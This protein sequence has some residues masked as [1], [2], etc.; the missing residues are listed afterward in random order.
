MKYLPGSGPTSGAKL[1]VITDAPTYSDE[2]DGKLFSGYN[3]RALEVALKEAGTSKNSCWITS[4]SKFHIQG[5]AKIPLKIRAEKDGID[6]EQQLSELRQE[7]S[8]IKPNCILALGNTAMTYLTGKNGITKYRG[9][10]LHG[11]GT[12]V[13]PAYNPIQLNSY[14]GAEFIGYY[15]KQIINFDFKRAYEESN[16]PEL[17]LPRRILTVCRNSAQLADFIYRHKHLTLPAI[18]IEAINCIPSCI[19]IAFTPNEG[20]SVP[21]WNTHGISKIP[22]SDMISIWILLGKLLASYDVVGQNLKYDEDKIKRLGFTFKS[23]I[24]DTMIKAFAINPEL[25]KSLAFNTSIYTREPYYKDEGHNFDIKKQSLDDL[26]IYNA[27]DACV[28]KEIDMKMDADI[29]ELGLRSYYENFLMKLHSLYLDIESVGMAIDK[30]KRDELLRKYVKWDES[31]R[32]ELF[33]LVGTEVNVNSSKQISILLYDNLRL[34]QRKGTGEEEITTLLNSNVVKKEEHRRILELILEGRR[35]RKTIANNIMAMPDFDGRMKTTYFLCL[36]TGRTSTGQQEP[37]IRPTVE[38]LDDV[39]KKKKKALGIPFQTIT[40][41]GDIGPEVRTMYVPEKGYM[42]VQID[43]SQAEARV[44]ALL[45]DDDITLGL[46]DTNDIHALTASWFFGGEEKDYSKR[47]LGYEHPTRFIGKTLRHAGHLGAGGKRAAIEVN[48]SARKYKIPIQI[49]Q[50]TAD[51]ALKVFHAKSPK[52]QQVF[53]ASV[54]ECLKNTRMLTAPVPYG[55]ESD[56]GGT[57][58]FYERWGDDLF[59]Q[60]FSYLPQRSISDNTKAAALRSRVIIPNLKIVMECHDSLLYQ[61]R[62]D[63]AKD[64]IPILK[65]EMERPIDFTTCSIKRRLLVIPAEVEVG[66]NYYEMG[67]WKN[68]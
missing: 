4:L 67:K 32:Y 61:I 54:V 6:L 45:S 19:G 27:R 31:I 10:I 9:S 46:Y 34:P 47:V 22:D 37:P 23:V 21:L 12:K 63:E 41:H 65:Q 17:N 20:I 59:R 8:T 40:K 36:E 25:P 33:K 60:A 55:I 38:V 42:F 39:G 51:N 68:G 13:V 3:G 66:D 30:E 11:Y 7:I 15:N 14:K 5:E 26:F 16:D 52:V 53:H 49:T 56:R 50:A 24:S 44:I 35:V 62:I 57:R 43:S 1:M 28:T 18:D 58:I 2:V 64:I 29:D 48:T